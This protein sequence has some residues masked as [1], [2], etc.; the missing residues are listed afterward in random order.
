M[1]GENSEVL[2]SYWIIQESKAGFPLE[3]SDYDNLLEII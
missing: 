2:Y 3:N 1:K